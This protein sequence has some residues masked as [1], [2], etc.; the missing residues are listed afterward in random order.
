MFYGISASSQQVFVLRNI[1]TEVIVEKIVKLEYL[2]SA[3]IR[4]FSIID[5]K[6]YFVSGPGKII[7]AE[8]ADLSFNLLCEYKVPFE[9][10]GMNDIAKIGS[11]FYL[12]VYQ[13]GTGDIAP[14]LVR[15]RD[16]KELETCYE[17]IY[18]LLNL[19]GT[20]YYF[21]FL[22]DRVFLTEIDS[23]S[24]IRS[25]MV[26]DDKICDVQV[27]YDMG[28]PNESSMRQRERK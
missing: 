15:V 12:S 19:E 1:E 5:G 14:R 23:Y 17:D 13:T 28:K 8:V 26:V 27:H 25:F 22:D 18:E 3:Y 16:L 9:F 7:V 24:A 21:S 11:Y 2:G 20:P 6:I 4:S 10:Q